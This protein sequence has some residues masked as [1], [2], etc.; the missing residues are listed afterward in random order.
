M[1]LGKSNYPCLGLKIKMKIV[2]QSQSCFK[3]TI[4]TQSWTLTKW[5]FLFLRDIHLHRKYSNFRPLQKFGTL[6]CFL[7]DVKS[8][9]RT[10]FMITCFGLVYAIVV[11]GITGCSCSFW[12]FFTRPWE[13]SCSPADSAEL[14]SS[15]GDI[16]SASRSTVC[17]KYLYE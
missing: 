2:T 10:G 14:C 13:W 3:I 12:E 4:L 9:K 1:V 7:K 6:V 15:N 11:F 16:K 5:N 8:W 17:R